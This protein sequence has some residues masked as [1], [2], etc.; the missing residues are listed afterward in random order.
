MF[1][2]LASLVGYIDPFLPTFNFNDHFHI[3]NLQLQRLHVHIL[4]DHVTVSIS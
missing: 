2:P 4:A 3:V 1:I